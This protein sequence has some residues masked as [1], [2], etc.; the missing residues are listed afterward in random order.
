MSIK[1]ILIGVFVLFLAFIFQINTKAAEVL[2][3]GTCGVDVTWKVDAEGTLTISGTGSMDNYRNPPDYLDGYRTTVKKIVI[4]EGVTHIG[5]YTFMN[6]YNATSVSIPKSVTSVGNHAFAGCNSLNAVHI[7]D[8][9]AWCKIQFSNHFSQPLYFAENLYLN[10]SL[11]MNLN[12]PN[13]VVSIGDYAFYNCNSLGKVSLPNGLVEIGVNAFADCTNLTNINIPDS[14]VFRDGNV[15]SNCIGLTHIKIPS[16]S[17]KI[18]GYTFYGCTNLVSVEI[19]SGI[20]NIGQHS[21][22]GCSSLKEIIYAGTRQQWDEIGIITANNSNAPLLNANILCACSHSYD[23]WVVLDGN[24]HKRV[25]KSCSHEETATHNWNGGVVSK[26]AT[27]KEEGIKRYSCFDCGTGKEEVIT[28]LTTHTYNNACD[29]TCNVCGLKRTVSHKYSSEWQGEK[30]S[31]YKLCDV[32]GNKSAESGHV[33]GADATTTTAQTCTVCEYVIKP[34]IGHKHNYNE[35]WESN[36]NIHWRECSCGY[37]IDETNHKWNAGI[38]S[39]EPTESEVGVKTY[40][41]TICN[42]KKEEQIPPISNENV[43]ETIDNSVEEIPTE[44]EKT[45]NIANAGE[46]VIK[47]PQDSLNDDEKKTQK[48][49]ETNGSIVLGVVLVITAVMGSSV[50]VVLYFKRRRNKS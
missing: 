31:H 49:P 45:E 43:S 28:K 27:C 26:V 36:V 1:K 19:H 8:V 25:C 32:C 6:V 29:S 2:D 23:S 4:E 35:S 18:P 47:E 13:G 50:I 34:P 10:N 40:N 9:T 3:S 22:T 11:V 48:K 5:A 33:P 46:Q 41:C 20:T 12:I 16:K 7:Y 17:T 39:K 30:N 37:R 15:F 38:V 21:F 14:V 24:T 44:E 42:V